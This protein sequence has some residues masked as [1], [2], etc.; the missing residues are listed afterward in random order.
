MEI[1]FVTKEENN[2]RREEEFRKF[3][4]NERFISFIAKLFFEH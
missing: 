1:F 3:S 2:S 4:P